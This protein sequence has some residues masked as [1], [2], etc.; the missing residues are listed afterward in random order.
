LFPLKDDELQT[1]HLI[2]ADV[3]GVVSRSLS[4]E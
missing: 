2:K 3:T 1:P 4:A